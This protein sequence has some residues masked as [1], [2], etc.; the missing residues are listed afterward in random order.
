MEVCLQRFAYKIFVS[1]TLTGEFI[2]SDEGRFL[3]MSANLQMSYLG[4]KVGDPH[5]FFLLFFVCLF[6]FFF[7]ISDVSNLWTNCSRSLE[8]NINVETFSERP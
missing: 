7:C 6:G 3:K 1:T 2:S 8:K 4:N 5:V